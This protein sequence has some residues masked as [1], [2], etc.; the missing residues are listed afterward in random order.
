MN[1]LTISK[2]LDTLA[3]IAMLVIFAVYLF[4]KPS[5]ILLSI[6]LILVALVKMGA[7]MMRASYYSKLYNE[8]KQERD[9]LKEQNEYLEN[10][11]KQNSNK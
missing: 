11:I 2:L 4:Q 7:S 3:L 10:E 8:V 6:Y 1:K 9:I 5:V